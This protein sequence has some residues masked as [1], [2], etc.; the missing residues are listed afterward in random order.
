MLDMDYL[1]EDDEEVLRLDGKTEE[2]TVRE[3][4]LW[5]GIG[6]GMSVADVCCGS[7]KTTSVL[8][9]LVGPTGSAVGIDG[10]EARLE[11]ARSHYGGPG[12]DFV[13]ADVREPLRHLGLFDFVWVRFVLEYHRAQSF[14]VL[15]NISEVVRPGGTLCLIDLDYNC[16]S[17]YGLSERLERTLLD[18]FRTLE[19]KGNFDPYAGRRQYTYLYRLGYGDIRVDVSAHHLIYGQLKDGEAF[20][21]LR[22]IEVA[23]RKIGYAFPQYEGGYEE[24]LDEFGRFF[25]DPARLTYTPVIAVRG[26]KPLA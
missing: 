13:S 24:F 23:S 5:A 11:Y 20:N 22:K 8:R 26:R 7:G 25:T 15:S 16:L 12:I 21:W 6:P 18:F 14:H 3:Q 1:M 10:S 2:N 9:V 17:H 4:A 19:E